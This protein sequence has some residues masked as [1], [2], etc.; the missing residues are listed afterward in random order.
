MYSRSSRSAPLVQHTGVFDTITYCV[1]SMYTDYEN[2]RL[3]FKK[4]ASREFVNYIEIYLKNGSASTTYAHRNILL[5]KKFTAEKLN[6]FKVI[7]VNWSIEQTIATFLKE[8]PCVVETY[9]CN[10]RKKEQ[11]PPKKCFFWYGE[12]ES[13]ELACKKCKVDFTIKREVNDTIFVKENINLEGKVFALVCVIEHLVGDESSKFITHIKRYQ[14]NWYTFSNDGV[15]T[16][17]KTKSVSPKILIYS[18]SDRKSKEDEQISDEETISKKVDLELE[19]LVS[20][21]KAIDRKQEEIKLFSIFYGHA[22]TVFV[23]E[24]KTKRKQI[25]TKLND[26]DFN[27]NV[28][29]ILADGKCLFRALAHQLFYHVIGSAELEAAT[30]KLREDVTSYIEQNFDVFK[31]IMNG[32]IYDENG[33]LPRDTTNLRN[34][35]LKDIKSG[36]IWGGGETI[37]AVSL[38][39][40]CNVLIFNPDWEPTV[41]GDFHLNYKRCAFITYGNWATHYDSVDLWDIEQCTQLSRTMVNMALKQLK[42]RQEAEKRKT[43]K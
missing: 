31:T 40:E 1:A 43:S 38:I 35:M 16:T 4:N 30:D 25:L 5:E 10:C 17:N 8:F 41:V 39:Y 27:I 6:G 23:A 11:K 26:T 12:F 21:Q 9:S 36:V 18:V 7:N 28:L 3:L 37:L 33:H 29:K 2:F 42:T 20:N 13:N 34:K 24:A 22:Q 15:T 32:R 19:L 14:T